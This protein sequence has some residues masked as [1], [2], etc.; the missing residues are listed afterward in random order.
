ML[1]LDAVIAIARS[2]VPDEWARYCEIA[3]RVIANVPDAPREMLRGARLRGAFDTT[4][5]WVSG[6]PEAEEAHALE[7][8][9]LGR[10]V[11]AV[12]ARRCSVRGFRRGDF[13]VT[14][15]DPMLIAVEAFKHIKGDQQWELA[16][17]MWYGVDVDIGP[18]PS[19]KLGNASNSQI[20]AEIRA[21]YNDCVATGRKPPN[22]KEIGKLVQDRLRAKQLDASTNRIQDLAGD[23]RYD[24]LRRKPGKT[25]ASEQRG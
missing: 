14:D 24:G 3:P 8:I 17:T 19:R 1:V 15:V 13:A 20:H 18:S 25:V 6:G 9:F 4:L 7:E 5:R 23:P 11:A 10:F 16:A 2:D 21:E 12:H 22:L